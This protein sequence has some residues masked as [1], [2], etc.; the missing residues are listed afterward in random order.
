MGLFGLDLERGHSANALANLP[1]FEHAESSTVE[2][3]LSQATFARWAPR[4]LIFHELEIGRSVYFLI[5][6]AVRLHNTNESGGAYTT[7]LARAPAQLGDL[8]LLAGLLEYR[9]SARALVPS[10]TASVPIEVI[11][12]ALAT[13][14]A[15]ALAW[16]EDLARR[17][18]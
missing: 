2:L 6:G 3:V 4:S 5:E 14:H 10:V 17:H 8:G 15:L 12:E 13:D 11:N 1:L 16:L 18:A 9:S 7:R